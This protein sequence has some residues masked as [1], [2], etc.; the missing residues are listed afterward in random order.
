[1]AFEGMGKDGVVKTSGSGIGMGT[2]ANKTTG[3]GTTVGNIRSGTDKVKSGTGPTSP[4]SNPNRV[5][6]K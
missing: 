4:E 1:M 6:H 3:E 5:G 2:G